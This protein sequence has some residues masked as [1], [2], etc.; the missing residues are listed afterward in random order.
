M[1]TETVTG[2]E[3]GGGAVMALAV[4]HARIDTDRAAKLSMPDMAFLEVQ[5]STKRFSLIDS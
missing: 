2:V 1:S 4:Q 5:I 3:S